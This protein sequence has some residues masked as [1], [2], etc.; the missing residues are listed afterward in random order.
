MKVHPEK[1]SREGLLQLNA[2]QWDVSICAVVC[3]MHAMTFEHF[4]GDV[5]GYPKHL[6]QSICDMDINALRINP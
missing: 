5:L 3:S 2:P 4:K 1:N 6:L